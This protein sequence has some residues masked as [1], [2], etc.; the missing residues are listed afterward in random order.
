MTPSPRSII[1]SSRMIQVTGD[2]GGGYGTHSG[3]E[4][5]LAAILYC[6]PLG[7][8]GGSITGCGTLLT[9]DEKTALRKQRWE[10][11]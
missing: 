10:I 7:E 11:S 6:S 4:R 8:L 2:D 9:E 5:L 3:R 1:V